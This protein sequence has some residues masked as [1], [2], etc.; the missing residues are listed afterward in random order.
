MLF[1]FLSAC[2][3]TKK[4]IP[5]EQRASATRRYKLLDDVGPKHSAEVPNIHKIRDAQPMPEPKS[6]WGNP[7]T[8][9]VFRKLYT[10]LPTSKGFVEQGKASWYGKKFHGYL[11]SNGEVYDMYGMSAAHKTLPLPTYAKVT[12]LDNGKSVIVKINDRG[13]FHD[14]RIIDLSY[15]AA[16]KLGILAKGLGNVKVEA[17]DP[18]LQIPNK[19]KYIQVGSFKHEQSAKDLALRLQKIAKTQVI[20][21]HR[22]LATKNKTYHVHIGPIA[23]ETVLRTLKD[24]II[25]NKFP[26]PVVIGAR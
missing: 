23:D 6:K 7:K 26:S 14:D 10:V 22:R 3:V 13:P 25:N 5:K 18:N 4:P 12:N 20:K 15:T 1:I 19:Q 11:T 16:S 8:Y 24:K 17:I 9:T 21:I 2:T